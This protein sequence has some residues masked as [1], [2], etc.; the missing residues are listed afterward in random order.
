MTSFERLQELNEKQLFF[1]VGASKSGTTWLQLLPDGH[2]AICSRGEGHFMDNLVPNLSKAIIG[3]NQL[4][5]ERNERAG[6]LGWQAHCPILDGND[7]SLLAQTAILTVFDRW[8]DDDA[9]TCIGDKT[10]EHANAMHEL[11][12]L[13]PKARFIHI[14]RDGRDVCLSG[15]LFAQKRDPEAMQKMTMSQFVPAYA[16]AWRNRVSAA[17]EFGKTYPDQYLEIRYEALHSAPEHEIERILSFLDVDTASELIALCQKAGAFETSAGG[18]ERGKEDQES[19]FRKG[20]VG[21]HK[22]HFDEE[23]LALFDNVAGELRTALG[24][25]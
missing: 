24:Y 19:F 6:A 1:V 2:P 5:A 8:L 20:V 17:R 25:D 9:V 22:N 4:S 3:F 7:L 16:E 13:F 18:R 11:A 10:P 23:T 12:G 15:W 21:D 14:I